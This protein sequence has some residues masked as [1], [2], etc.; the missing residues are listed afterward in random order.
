MFRR[1]VDKLVQQSGYGRPSVAPT[2]RLY[3]VGDVHGRH[4]LLD[5]MLETLDRDIARF[6]DGRVSRIV[7]LG[8]YIDRG[9]H[10]RE[11]LDTLCIA[12]RDHPQLFEFLA[13]NHEAALLH[14]LDD[15]VQGAAWLEWGGQQTLKSYGLAAVSRKPDAAEL[16][17]VRDRL[18]EALGPHLAFLQDLT[19]YVVS[20][21]VVFVHAALD[22][23]L[24]L[25][26]Q[27]DTA[28]LWGQLPAGRKPGLPGYR[29]VH[30]H[31]AHWEP[32]S[33]RGRLCVD[34]G[35]YY[36]DRLTA[37]R[38]DAEETFLH[39]DTNTIPP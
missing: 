26:N 2:E 12:K 7:F 17:A 8:D 19:R 30:G 29:L 14:F 21:N 31:F 3:A 15:P 1:L 27:P 10:S 36:T 16:T 4:D 35:A 23:T 20:G 11:V 6:D 39:A 38:L 25:G 9:E 34:T 37:V 32:V 5:L 18:C 22:P 28:L 33:R 24:T 13:G